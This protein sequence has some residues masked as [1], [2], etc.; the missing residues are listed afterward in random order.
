MFPACA[1]ASS[2]GNLCS[3]CF[4]GNIL[5]PF[6]WVDSLGGGSSITGRD[7]GVFGVRVPMR[8]NSLSQT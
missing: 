8:Y 6:L 1:C 3:I 5:I 4:G 7:T 2:I